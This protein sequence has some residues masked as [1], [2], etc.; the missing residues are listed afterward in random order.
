MLAKK[1]IFILL[2]CFYVL[3]FS[4]LAKKDDTQDINFAD[5]ERY[6]LSTDD[7]IAI[8]VFNE[9]DLSLDSVRITNNGTVNLPL[10]GEVE[11]K[12]LNVVQVADKITALLL[13][14]YLKKPNV[15]VR[16]TQY[17]PFYINGEVKKTG[18]YAYRKGLNIEKA[19]TLAGG[20]TERA[21]KKGIVLVR[22]GEEEPIDNV[23][24]KTQVH[25]GDV[26][27]IKESFF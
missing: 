27:T 22:E 2:S 5:E 1:L 18:S 15:S 8:I 14:G 20:F 21:T 25:P 26:I 23:T 6:I 11:V 3:S 10:L 19:V 4:C 7:N 17:R 13:N 12:G 24:L 9:E 16:I